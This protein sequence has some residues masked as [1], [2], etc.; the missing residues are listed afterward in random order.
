MMMAAGS[1]REVYKEKASQPVSKTP[2]LKGKGIPRK[3]AQ[4]PEV[5]AQQPLNDLD[6]TRDSEPTHFSH[7]YLGRGE[8]S[9]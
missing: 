9:F 4:Q 5:V 6:S 2:E 1:R 3:W 7:F 8:D